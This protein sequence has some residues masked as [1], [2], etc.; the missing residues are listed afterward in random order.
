MYSGRRLFPLFLTALATVS[1]AARGEP[2]AYV[3]LGSA[4]GVL[5]VDAA[6]HR[7]LYTIRGLPEV[8]GLAISPDG[9]TLL[10]GS[11][12]TGDAGTIPEKPAGMSEADHA[13]HH[14][15]GA[16]PTGGR[17]SHLTLVKASDGTV[18][19]RIPVVGAVHHVEIAPN[20][21]TAAATHPGGGGISLVDLASGNVTASVP[22]GA[23]PNYMAFTT[24]GER[25]YVSNAGD[26]S[27]SELTF[28]HGIA[29]RKLTVGGAPEH[30]VLSRDDARLYVNDVNSGSVIEIDTRSWLV[31]RRFEV[32]GLLH[33]IDLSADGG[34]IYAAARERNAMAVIDLGSGAV[35]LIPLSPAP[36]HLTVLGATNTVYVTSASTPRIWAVDGDSL[37]VRAEIPI[38]GEGHQIAV[39]R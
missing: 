29:S 12:L 35:S 8:H 11:L 33:G 18:L 34:R 14:G 23:E 22:T 36:Y 30:L 1:T 9:E 13:A 26:G 17:I 7:A 10:A 15:G 24:D 2:I 19:R 25:L 16:S 5:V 6:D 3:P 20:G 27:I 38:E 37:T 28:G 4:A 32:G 39:S 31:A 21:R